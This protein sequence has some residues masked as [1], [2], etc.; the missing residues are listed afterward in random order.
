MIL[1][2][3]IAF[4]V[5]FMTIIYTFIRYII[6]K[7]IIYISYSLMQVFSLGFI[8]LYSELFYSSKTIQDIFLILATLSAVVFSL[9]F[10]K[11]KFLPTIKNTKELI[12]NTLLLNLVILTAFYHYMLFEYLPYTVIY[13][14]LFISIIFNIK[15]SYK[16]TLVYVIGWSIF[17]L[18]LFIVD[19]KHIYISKGF[20]DIVLVAFAIEAVLFTI[21]ISYTYTNL[22]KQKAEYE[23]MLL[24][25][26]RLAKSGEMIRNITHQFRQPLNNI[27]YITANLKKRYQNKKLEAE[28]FY[29]KTDQIDEQLQFLSTTIDQF[30]EFYTPT[31]QKTSFV[32][33]D[34]L[35]NSLTVLSSELKK[36]N[37]TLELTFKISEKVKIEGIKNELSQVLVSILVNASDALKDIEFPKIEI[38]VDGDE[39]EVTIDIIN[40]GK[41]IN[42]LHLDKIFEPYF[43]TKEDGT[44]IGLYLSRVIMEKSFHGTIQATNLDEGVKFTLTIEKTI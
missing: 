36:R 38:L 43:S 28:Y 10:Y 15:D 17:C 20:I 12:V 6:S 29:K 40:N 25:Q 13:G 8:V 42:T 22:K 35:E 3:G 7:E 32:L 30:Q 44:G 21:S 14:I 34:V 26:S 23:D 24:S 1:S 4:G 16:P 19:F 5:V 9:S 18:V 37:I 33:K 31:K 39:A 27:S 41:P 2:F 11:G